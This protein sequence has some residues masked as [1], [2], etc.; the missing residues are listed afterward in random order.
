MHEPSPYV[1]DGESLGK[2]IVGV[3]HVA[4]PVIHAWPPNV[5]TTARYEPTRVSLDS[6][7]ESE[8]ALA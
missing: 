7:S 4:I 8:F 6:F 2:W 3:D 1:S 5:G